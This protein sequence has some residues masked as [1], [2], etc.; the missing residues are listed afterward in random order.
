MLAITADSAPAHAAPWTAPD[1]CSACPGR[2]HSICRQLPADVLCRLGGIG[3][4]RKL[5]RGETLMWD[6]DEAETVANV[7]SG[8]LQLSA[9]TA[10]GQEQIL[11]LMM[12]GDFVGQPFGGRQAERVVALSDVS[13]CV[14]RRPEFGALLAEAPSLSQALL[15]KTFGDLARAR[16]WLQLLGRKSAEERI[17]SLLW[18]LFE[19]A[20]SVPGEPVALLL[21]RQQMADLLGLTIETVSR[22]LRHLER[23]GL[24]ALPDLRSFVVR[25]PEAL[26]AL[27]G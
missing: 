24:I 6:G 9:G 15:E 4:T 21:S 19:R 5:K 7:R 26:E 1:R 22:R 2:T 8:M 14:F 25:Q 27:A 20:G 16:G 3:R 13:V 17:V 18:Q 10:N 11:G 12:P 23:A